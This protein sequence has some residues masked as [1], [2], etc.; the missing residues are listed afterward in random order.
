M[1]QSGL[2]LEGISRMK[3]FIIIG[4]LT[5]ALLAVGLGTLRSVSVDE[6]K[7]NAAGATSID[8]QDDL[9]MDNQSSVIFEEQSG[10]GTDTFTLQ[11]P[12]A[13][14]GDIAFKL[15]DADGSSGD[16]LQTDGSGNLS[17][18]TPAAS[19]TPDSAASLDNAA[20]ATSV[21]S[22]ALTIALKTQDAG[23]PAA[24]DK[25]RVSFRNATATTG[26]YSL[27]EITG[28]LSL[29]I[30]S[31]STLGQTSAITDYIYVYLVNNAGTVIL[32]ASG[33]KF[34]EGSLHSTTAEGGAGAADSATL[35]YAASA[36]S[37]K[38]VRLI[39]RIKNT[40]TTAGTWASAGAELSNVP[41][42]ENPTSM[43]TV[44]YACEITNTG[45]PAKLNALCDTWVSSID[46]DS[47]GNWTLQFVAG[48]FG[49]YPPVFS[50][51]AEGNNF[52]TM[53]G[54]NSTVE[55]SFRTR[56]DAA[57]ADSDA[58]VVCVG[59]K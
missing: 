52:C 39:G 18:V 44:V 40:Q 23:D 56:T 25:V 47:T 26:D 49:V 55:K 20:I 21:G 53:T 27:I 34:D 38:A 4:S 43:N 22:S 29:V 19:D 57:A 3:L 45:V 9:L 30:S 50:C 31:G 51:V 1:D 46:D 5:I 28:A 12:D 42:H 48:V 7:V 33:S 15:P 17:F 41:F 8:V 36:V 54:T 11:A 14:A 24:G 59:Y 37:S 35:L 16:A 2:K 32:A 13:L 6:L 10:N 58:N